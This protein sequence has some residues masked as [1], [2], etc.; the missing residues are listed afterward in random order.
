LIACACAC[1]TASDDFISIRVVLPEATSVSN[2][3]TAL[4]I[5]TKL[6]VSVSIAATEFLI[7]VSKAV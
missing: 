1:I 2:Q 7:A 4:F 6:F 3:S 5:S